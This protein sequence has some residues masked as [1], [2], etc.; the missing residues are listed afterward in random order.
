MDERDP[1]DDG[2]FIYR[3]IHRVFLDPKTQILVQF[4][5]FRPNQND[6]T[7]ISVFRAHFL[8]PVDT[9]VHIDPAKARDYCVA[10]LAVGDLR[11]LGLTVIP[12]PLAGGP[13]G[14][15]LIPELSLATYQAHKKQF[16]MVLVVFQSS[17]D[18]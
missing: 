16:K 11:S 4:P 6:T 18:T 15:A 9:L 8:R 5:A 3:R 12:N 13:P 17:I 2:E 1:V 14:H 10:R 7:G